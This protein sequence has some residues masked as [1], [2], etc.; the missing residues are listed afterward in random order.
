[1]KGPATNVA[2]ITLVLVPWAANER[3]RRIDGTPKTLGRCYKMGKSH[4]K[5]PLN[6][7]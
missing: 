1:M 3:N 2:D 7:N 4:Q 5:K 6:N